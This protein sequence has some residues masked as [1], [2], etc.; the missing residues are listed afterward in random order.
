MTSISLIYDKYILSRG[1]NV[2][3]QIASALKYLHSQNIVFRDLK[4]NN[5]GFDKYGIVKLFDFGLAREL[6]KECTD[7]NDVYHM[8]GMVGTLRYMAPEV[9]FSKHYNQKI[10]TYSWATVFWSCL[11]LTIPYPTTKRS[12]YLKN[13]CKLGERPPMKHKWPESIC[14]LLENTWAQNPY[15]RLTMKEV[16]SELEQI[17]LE[18]R[19]EAN[20]MKKFKPNSSSFVVPASLI[21]DTSNGLVSCS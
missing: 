19:L 5:V 6:P 21:R 3:Y 15:D 13:V 9:A 16:C 10:D 1:V 7:M 11:S 20:T 12:E 14:N 8:S 18:L 17:E 2:A 4:P